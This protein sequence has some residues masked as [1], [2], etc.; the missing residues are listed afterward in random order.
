MENGPFT[1]D[2]PNKTSIYKGFSMAMFNNQMVWFMKL[3]MPPS[4]GMI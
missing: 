1:D 4:N 2:V 3:D